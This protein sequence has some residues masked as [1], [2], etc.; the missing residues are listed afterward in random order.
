MDRPG[1]GAEASWEAL[2]G[3]VCS[4][5]SPQYTALKEEVRAAL[6]E[7]PRKEPRLA[8]R[9]RRSPCGGCAAPL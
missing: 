6:E 9:A 8:R 1:P 7:K 4:D 5:G 3:V 2:L